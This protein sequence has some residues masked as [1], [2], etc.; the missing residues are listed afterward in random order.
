[1]ADVG[2]ETYKGASRLLITSDAGGSNSATTRLWK[3]QLQALADDTGLAISV[4]HIPPGTRKWNKIEHQ[5]FSHITQNWRGR[6]LTSHEVVVNLIANTTTRN[7]LK[8]R[9]GLDTNAYPTKVTVSDEE[10][11]AVNLQRDA[12]Q[13]KWNYTILPHEQKSD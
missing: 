8:V 9:A 5:L 13:G 6:P 2:S 1:M 4:C 11:A 7:G 12:F 3:V 10:L